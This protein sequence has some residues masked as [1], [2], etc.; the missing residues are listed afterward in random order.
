M[1]WPDLSDEER[2]KRDKADDEWS[3]FCGRL[4]VEELLIAKIIAPETAEWAREII[5]QQIFVLLVSDVRPANS[6]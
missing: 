6:N 2:Q 5:A 1:G 4:A 3:Q